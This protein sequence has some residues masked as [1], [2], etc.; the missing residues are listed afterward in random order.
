MAMRTLTD[1][2]LIALACFCVYAVIDT[3]GVSHTLD[4]VATYL[5]GLLS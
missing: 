4:G 2:L 1:L 3:D 5:R